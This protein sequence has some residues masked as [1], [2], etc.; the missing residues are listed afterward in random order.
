MFQAPDG[1]IHEVAGRIGQRFAQLGG[2]DGVLGAPRSNEYPVP[3]GVRVDFGRRSLVFNQETGA[4]TTLGPPHR[5][6]SIIRHRL[7]RPRRLHQQKSH[8]H[9]TCRCC[10]GTVPSAFWL[11]RNCPQPRCS[12]RTVRW[13][14]RRELSTPADP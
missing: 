3:G 5:P 6:P 7:P 11:G 8:L 9:R 12:D 13:F 1:Q 14:A 10:T 2:N 4:V